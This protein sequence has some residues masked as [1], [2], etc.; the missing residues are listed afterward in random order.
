MAKTTIFYA[1]NCALFAAR[2]R[3]SQHKVLDEIG[4][5]IAKRAAL[6][7]PVDT[8]DLS[9]SMNYQINPTADSVTIG[10]AIDYAAFQ[11][12]GTGQRGKGTG[13]K[14]PSNY[15]HG[16]SAGHKAQPFLEPAMIESLPEISAVAKR[17]FKRVDSI[18]E[19]SVR[20]D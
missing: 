1:S 13:T 3:Q 7:A 19:L 20:R 12:F 16:P 8:G 5:I 6:E 2:L 4:G 17:G 15:R 11:E 10:T 14:P 18:T 9:N